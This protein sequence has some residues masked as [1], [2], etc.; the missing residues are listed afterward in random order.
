MTDDNAPIFDEVRR[1]FPDLDF[2]YV[3]PTPPEP[4]PPTPQAPESETR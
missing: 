1:L 4:A 3:D 2:R